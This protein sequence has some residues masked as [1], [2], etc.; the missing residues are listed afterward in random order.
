MHQPPPDTGEVI[1]LGTRSRVVFG[2]NAVVVAVGVTVQ[3][4]V[5]AGL[6]EGFFDTS[7]KRT[8]NVLAFFTI[9]S[10]LVVGVTTATLA[11]GRARPTATFQALRLIGLVGITLTFVV[12]QV[13]LKDLQ[14]LTGAA[15]LA[16]F[17][18]HTVSPVM[19]VGGWLLFGP[20]GQTPRVAVLWS[21]AFL[22]TWGSFTLVRG[23]AVG[24]YPYPF[25]NP[26]D[27]GYGRVVV[28]LV[29]VAG[30]FVGLAGIARLAD[31]R[32]P[33]RAAVA[34]TP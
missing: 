3:L 32:L 29:L 19:C 2:V 28:N 6:D 34:A 21:L 20:R 4:F 13:A 30:T 26:I 12:F 5:T 14:D 27:Q 16:D 1:R 25:M 24:W 8:L 10:N 11:A 7:W 17:C 23:H 22:A 31:R 9:Q 15:K 33:H 18:L